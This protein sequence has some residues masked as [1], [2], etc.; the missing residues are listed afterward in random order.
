MIQTRQAIGPTFCR[1][2]VVND[3]V[4]YRVRPPV[5]T[6]GKIWADSATLAGT[7]AHHSA[8]IQGSRPRAATMVFDG[9]AGDQTIVQYAD[10]RS[11]S[12]SR[13]VSDENAIVQC[14][15][16]CAASITPVG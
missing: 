11:A 13:S 5:A 12:R 8:V 6:E 10:C 7:V 1:R 14:A 15:T 16:R 9:I 3:A 2:V 4:A